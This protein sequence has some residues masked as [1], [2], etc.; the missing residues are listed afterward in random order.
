MKHQLHK[1]VP[2]CTL[3]AFFHTGHTLAMSELLDEKTALNTLLPAPSWALSVNC[4][5]DPQA[6]QKAIYNSRWSVQRSQF[7][8]AGECYGPIIIDKRDIEVSNDA[9]YSGSITLN[10]SHISSELST[11]EVVKISN[12]TVALTNIAIKMNDI[13]RAVTVTK[14][15]VVTLN[16][17]SGSVKPTAEKVTYPFVVT[18]NSTTYVSNSTGAGFEVSGSSVMQFDSE[19]NGHFLNVLDTSVARSVSQNQFESVQV[20]GN[21]YFLGDNKTHI[22]SL[23]VWSKASAEVNRESSVA[24]LQM[25]G[26]TLFA[27]Y[28]NSSISGPYSLYGNVVFELEHSSASN[29]VS[30]DKPQSILLGNNAIVNGTLYPSWS[31]AGQDGN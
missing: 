5:D 14:N 10:P 4:H 17:I 28:R 30:V 27:A 15:S 25:G 3:I 20:S 2:V 29:W 19:N 12:S 1:L 7:A 21:T 26:Q 9:P 18:D 8:I 11:T 6:L 16:N 23:M 24:Q 13:P 31:W 22:E